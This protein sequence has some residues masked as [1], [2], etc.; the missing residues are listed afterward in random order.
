MN[1]RSAPDRSCTSHHHFART[2][3][4]APTP[5]AG[6]T[7]RASLLE[8]TEERRKT[9][10]RHRC[11][12]STATHSSVVDELQ[13]IFTPTQRPSTAQTSTVPNFAYHR[14]P[15][16]FLISFLV[17]ILELVGQLSE[18]AKSGPADPP[19]HRHRRLPA[20]DTSALSAHR[21]E[22]RS[23]RL[24]PYQ[25]YLPTGLLLIVGI[26][27]VFGGDLRPQLGTLF[28]RHHLGK[29]LPL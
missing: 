27:R 18:S 1:G 24:Q 6:S 23:P 11:P 4:A 7:V 15:G 14:E 5:D 3:G 17:S 10:Y 9:H 13:R 2:S 29:H 19:L 28:G 22:P 21:Q 8:P 25:R 20:T 16:R 12:T 26:G